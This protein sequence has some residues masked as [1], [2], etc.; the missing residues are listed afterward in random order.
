MK[1]K[2]ASMHF[3]LGSD[4]EKEDSDEEEENVKN[5]K[6]AS[7]SYSYHVDRHRM[8]EPFI[9]DEKSTKRHVVGTRNFRK[10]L[11]LPRK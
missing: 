3:F 5:F 11:M 7:R 10:L 8:S 2:S 4:E 1:V 9:T 6:S